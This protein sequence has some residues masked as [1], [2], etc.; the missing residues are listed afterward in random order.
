DIRIAPQQEPQ[1]LSRPEPSL[2]TPPNDL[3]AANQPYP[4]QC[5][6]LLEHPTLRGQTYL[7][8]RLNPLTYEPTSQR[9]LL[10]TNLLITLQLE[11]TP[12][13]QRADAAT[14]DPNA[15]LF[16]SLL[17]GLVI[18]PATTIPKTDAF[19]TD[20]TPT[21][22]CD[23]LIITSDTLSNSFQRLADFRTSQNNLTT[24]VLTLETIE[25]SYSG[26][27]PAG[28]SDT[29]TKIRN[30][31]IDY[32]A[33]FGTAYVL[34]GGD[35]TILPDRD[36]AVSCGSYSESA[37]PTDLYYSGLDGTWDANAN[38][39]YGETDDSVDMAYDVIVGRLPIR[40]TTQADA[41]INKLIDFESNALPVAFMRKTILLGDKLWNTYTGTVRPTDTCSDGLSQFNAH[42]PVADDE[43]WCRRL[44]RTRLSLWTNQHM[45]AFFD[46]LT[47]WDSSTAG[48]YLQSAANVTA[49]FNEGWNHVFFATHGNTT[50]WG[51]ESGSFSSSHAAALTN[52]QALVYTMACLTGAFDTAD[53]SLS[54]GFLRNANGGA[55]AYMG[56]SRYGWGSPGS[57]S[58]GTSISYADKFYDQ[59][60]TKLRNH[61]G[62]A[63]AEHKLA[64]ASS[65]TYNGANR[66]VQ[67]GMNLQGEPLVPIRRTDIIPGDDPFWFRAS[68]LTNDVLLRWPNP[69]QC[70]MSSDRVR[71]DCSTADYPASHSS[72]P[73]YEGTNQIFLDTDLPQNQPRYYT[74]WV[75]HDGV[76][77]TNPLPY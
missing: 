12:D 72:S 41:Y 45:S 67:F 71:I 35:N 54:E 65:S 28:G 44:Y 73:I 10:A 9:L 51:L 2:P 23:Y 16:A 63:F 30:A 34:L 4:A 55:L 69:I 52:L 56:C 17:N 62:I 24:R 18:N 5:A 76:T 19:E 26:T 6:V 61:I 48:D 60:F 7:A 43:I 8:I 31:I 74:I 38:G 40:T 13:I 70:G 53:P 49:R 46:T 22:T 27:K 58:G 57:Y 36:A 32:V 75:T 14:P 64:M 66:W 11:T 20:E 39:T 15:S 59:V 68:A 25:T 33:R 50:I 47:S 29:Q 21:A 37:M 42:D 1:P 3:F 77:W